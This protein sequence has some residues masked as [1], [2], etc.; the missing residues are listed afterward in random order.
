MIGKSILRAPAYRVGSGSVRATK[1]ARSRWRSWASA[2][3][4]AVLFAAAFFGIAASENAASVHAAASLGTPSALGARI[5]IADFDGDRVPDLAVVQGGQAA[6]GTARYW[7]ALQLSSGASQTLAIIAPAGGLRLS[8]RDV[9]AD[10]AL[11]ILVTTFWTNQPVAVLLNGG[12]GDFRASSPAAFLR[13]FESLA[14]PRIVE[15]SK[16]ASPNAILASSKSPRGVTVAD[17]TT[18]RC[19][20]GR[21]AGPPTE[22]RLAFSPASPSA[23]RA[24]PKFLA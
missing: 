16:I 19:G 10:N 11:D 1:S 21:W 20:S 2:F 8:S 22:L 4:P 12:R 9:N 14:G 24:P 23:G 3:A 18:P 6:A 13:S 7:I 15:T 5:A 17:R